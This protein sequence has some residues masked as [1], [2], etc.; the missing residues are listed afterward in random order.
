MNPRR[1]YTF[2]ELDA[3]WLA[4]IRFV[5]TCRWQ[6]YALNA[7]VDEA[8]LVLRSLFKHTIEYTCAYERRQVS[9]LD[10]PA[11][12]ETVPTTSD[13]EVRHD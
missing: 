4:A 3:G 13:C 12:T 10:G 1:K 9:R 2:Q 6:S 11:S 8:L 5:E 7:E